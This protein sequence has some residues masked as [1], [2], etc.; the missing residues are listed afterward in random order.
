MHVG[1]IEH[2]V[3]EIR[4][5]IQRKPDSRELHAFRSRVDSLERTVRELGAEIVGIRNRLQ[6]VDAWRVRM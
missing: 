6:E 5:L 2:E 3:R 1:G 4:S